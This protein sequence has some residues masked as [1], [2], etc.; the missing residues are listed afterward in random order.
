MRIAYLA[1]LTS[2]NG[3]Y[4]AI[5]P[6]EAL[7]RRGH[8]VYNVPTADP[9]GAAAAMPGIDVLHVHRFVEPPVQELVRAARAAGTVVVWDNDDDMGSVPKGTAAYQHT[10][11]INW[12]RRLASMRRLFR[13]VTLVTSPSAVLA[14][15]L[16]ELGAARTAV[17]ENFVPD[18]FVQATPEP[19][20][21]VVIGWIAGLEHQLDAERMPIR[22][23]L[24]R[25]L[26]ERPEVRVVT[27]G[28]RL[29]LKSPRYENR[30][31]IPLLEL[32]QQAAAFDVAIAP[33]LDLDFN[34]SRSNV[35]LKEYAAAGVPWLA[36][37]VGPYAELGEKH[38][39]RLVPDDGWHAAL[40]QL[41]DRPRERRKL[42]KRGR[43]WAAGQ[44]ITKNAE[45]WEACLGE[46]V[47]RARA[48]A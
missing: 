42:A 1:D 24:E 38:G 26:E 36:S 2:A 23:V 13:D 48:A 34:R 6:M 10:G 14:Q 35:K 16:G 40:T 39:G 33:I 7:E 19:H 41:I 11:G 30:K 18:E 27:L 9:R 44:T 17:I 20:D 31:H 21:G 4:R 43:R 45:R 47:A 5:G 3:Y 25:L 15:R 22:A 8:Q 28:L 32:A 46:V 37:P 29:G 12:E